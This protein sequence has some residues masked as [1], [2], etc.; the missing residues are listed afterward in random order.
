[1]RESDFKTAI[2]DKSKITGFMIENSENRPVLFKK[3]MLP[4]SIYTSEE[5][6]LEV[7]AEGK[8]S[9][10]IHHRREISN[11]TDEIF[12]RDDYYFMKEG[13]Y[14]RFKPFRFIITRVFKDEKNEIRALTREYKMKFKTKDQITRFVNLYNLDK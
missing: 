10:Y 2:L 11:S 8:L 6:F 12:V 7:L 9:L 14:I 13:Q 1:M 3:H 4:S 5:T